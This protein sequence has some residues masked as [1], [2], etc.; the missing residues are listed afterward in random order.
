MNARYQQV[1]AQARRAAYRTV[2][3]PGILLLLI[4]GLLYGLLFL[5]AYW[6][7]IG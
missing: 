5:T 7:G 6:S 1:R 3:L 2:R 4:V